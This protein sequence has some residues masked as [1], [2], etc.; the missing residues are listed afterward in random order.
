MIEL[1]SPVTLR[2]DMDLI[3]SACI[4]TEDPISFPLSYTYAGRALRGLPEGAK[5]SVR[6]LD[7]NMLETVYDARIP[8]SPLSLRVECV[9]YRDFPVVEWTAYFTNGGDKDSAILEDV[10]AADMRFSGEGARLTA[11][12]GDSYSGSGY[13][14]TAVPLGPGA[15]FV[16]SPTEGRPCNGAWP[17]QRLT[18][19]GYGFNIAIGWPAQWESAYE[20]GDGFVRFRARQQTVHTYLRPGETLRTPRMCVMAFTGGA[21]RGVNMWRRWMNAH[22]TPRVH[23]HIVPPRASVSEPGDGEEHTAC[24]DDLQFRAME[25][26]E[27]MGWGKQLLWWIDA[28]WYPCYTQ[29][30]VK[31]WPHT[32]TWEPDRSKFPFGMGRVGEKAHQMGIDYLI[33]YEPER[34]RPGTEL[35]MRHPEWLLHAPI[36]DEMKRSGTD[37]NQYNDENCMLNLADDDCCDWLC[38]HFETLIRESGQDVY[39]QDFNFSPLPYWRANEAPD[40]R[41]M[42]E[43]KYQQNYLRFWDYLLSRNP[44][45]WI[46]SCASGGRRNDLETMRRAVPLHPTDYGYGYHPVSQDFRRTLHEWIPY[47]R[48]QNYN[49]LSEDGEHY[50]PLDRID[51]LPERPSTNYDLVNGMGSLFPLF[52]VSRALAFPGQ[53]AY[54]AKMLAVW[55]KFAPMQLLG[56]FYP[57]TPP[58]RSAEKWTVFQFDCPDEGCGAFQVLRNSMAMEDSVT[59]AP[60][61]LDPDSEYELRNGE[62]GES[63][64]ETGRSLLE[65]GVTFAQGRPSGSIWF[66]TRLAP[67]SSQKTG[68]ES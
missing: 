14:Q 21:E 32:G 42:L 67:A 47:T 11:G 10:W 4:S 28:G 35:A 49:W 2:E 34:V 30:G 64:R 66:Y 51:E 63:R 55:E 5:R 6:F 53:S 44:G 36:T 29:P 59:L 18:F 46:D 12:N 16:Q 43:N 26:L 27:K 19:E 40:R 45:L 52:R 3:R 31:K 8:D 25:Q 41:G 39:R 7:A 62:T 60:R 68:A 22:V 50:Q 17:Y 13:T 54:I 38:R 9:T 20:G 23:G 61:A 37:P 33:W 48:A 65:R 56:D 1:L 57:L 15:S 58:H 24:T